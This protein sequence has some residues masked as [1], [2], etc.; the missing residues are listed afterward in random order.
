MTTRKWH[1]GRL[2]FGVCTDLSDD[3]VIFLPPSG[4]EVWSKVVDRPNYQKLDEWRL[5]ELIPTL[6]AECSRTLTSQT[7]SEVYVDPEFETDVYGHR[8]T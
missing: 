1:E 3:G 5:A 7:L 8:Q 4:S 6:E 2:D